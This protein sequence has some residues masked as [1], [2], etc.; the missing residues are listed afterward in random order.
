MWHRGE[1]GQPAKTPPLSAS[2]PLHAAV[3]SAAPEAAKVPAR[4]EQEAPALGLHAS[5]QKAVF[6]KQ[7]PPER[8]RLR[9][10]PKGGLPKQR[11]ARIQGD[12]IRADPAQALAARTS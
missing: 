3:K 7:V 5:A 11:P 12:P 6:L 10:D 2:A 4:A 1:A 9:T 8:G